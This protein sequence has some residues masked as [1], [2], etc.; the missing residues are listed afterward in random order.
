MDSYGARTALSTVAM[1][2]LTGFFFEE[3][4]G[5]E[6][7][8]A[9][10]LRWAVTRKDAPVSCTEAGAASV[11][12]R[13]SSR[14]NGDFVHTA[15]CDDGSVKLSVL[16]DEVY[17]VRLELHSSSGAVLGAAGPYE[18]VMYERSD[19]SFAATFRLEAPESDSFAATVVIEGQ[20]IPFTPT[21]VRGGLGEV[22]GQNTLS[23]LP[24]FEALQATSA[25]VQFLTNPFRVGNSGAY[26]FAPV[27]AFGD[28]AADAYLSFATTQFVHA[29]DGYEVVFTCQSGTLTISRYGS[30]VGNRIAGSFSCP[31]SG[32]RI[33]DL[34]GHTRDLRG[35]IN[36]SFD[37][38]LQGT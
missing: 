11:V 25:S 10:E 34:Q 5:P 20:P 30:S 38:E 27:E 29:D 36:G 8:G 24:G 32:Q 6:G 19:W 17:T 15:P 26:Q 33:I 28:G 37:L 9:V 13:F 1:F 21:L 16:A 4:G 7:E 2:A 18:A 22:T 35:T 3:C 14:Y 31:L 12:A 23:R